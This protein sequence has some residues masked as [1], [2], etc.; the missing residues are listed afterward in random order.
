MNCLSCFASAF[1]FMAL[2][3][4]SLAQ[5]PVA[6]RP[7][8]NRPQAAPIVNPSA[9]AVQGTAWIL[10]DDATG[11]VLASHNPDER[12]EPASITKVMTSY[13]VSAEIAAGKK[14]GR[15]HV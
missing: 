2:A 8:P 10:V 1:L 11:Q 6:D 4:P 3:A 12:V 7:V 5:T 13:V 9:P 15:A 14:I